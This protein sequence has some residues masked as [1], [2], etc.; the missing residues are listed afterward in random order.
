MRP[1]LEFFVAGFPA[2]QPRV[3]ATAF[4]GHARVYTPTTVKTASGLRKEHPS[5]SW[6]MIVRTEAQRA[7]GG[8]APWEGPLRVDLTFVFPRPKAHFRSNGELK[9][10]AP[11]WHTGK[12]DRDNSDKAVL[13]ALT[14]LGLW[15]D[16]QQVCD[17][18]IKKVY[19]SASVQ[20]GC[21]IRISE[22]VEEAIC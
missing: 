10:F 17:G 5:A 14:D 9:P 6:K 19:A 18:R 2:G 3:K 4:G 11:Y 16:D 12:P 20:P 1:M 13:D 15:G 7:W 8:S 21:L 22:A